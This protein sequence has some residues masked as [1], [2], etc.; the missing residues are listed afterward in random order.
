M[1]INLCTDKLQNIEHFSKV[2]CS[3]FPWELFAVLYAILLDL[4]SYA[5][6][7]KCKFP[8]LHWIVITHFP[9]RSLS[10]RSLILA[11]TSFA[12][13]NLFFAQLGKLTSPIEKKTMPMFA[14]YW[15]NYWHPFQPEIKCMPALNAVIAANALQISI[16]ISLVS[17]IIILTA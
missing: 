1:N 13:Y 15:N 6:C 2:S 17:C 7:V 12:Y 10:S 11:T 4:K 8:P 14:S 9:H 16:M 5:F 3:N